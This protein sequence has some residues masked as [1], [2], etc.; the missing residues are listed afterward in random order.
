MQK[1]W[2][3]GSVGALSFLTF[4]TIGAILQASHLFVQPVQAAPA[5]T[6]ALSPT[7]PQVVAGKPIR[8]TIPSASIDLPLDDGVY[9]PV[10]GSWTLSDTRAQF[11][12]MT[13]PANN[14]AG[15]T[16]VYGHGTDAVFGRIGTSRPAVGTSA[17]LYTDNGHVFAYR[18]TATSD[19]QPS[20]TSLFDNV[21]SGPPRLV[22]QTCTGI[23]SE[24]RTMFDFAFEEVVQ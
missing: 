23:F 7:P 18:L 1:L 8:I 21:S 10:D 15:T 5:V 14:H 22:V 17:Y 11:A 19:L 16:F 20:D 24:W 12:L 13:V 2:F 6:A 9:N 4:G 3:F